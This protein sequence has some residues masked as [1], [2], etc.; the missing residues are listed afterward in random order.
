M[1]RYKFI[2]CLLFLTALLFSAE[3]DMIGKLYKLAQSLQVAEMA[4]R[5]AWATT[6]EPP[7]FRLAWISDAHVMNQASIANAQQVM[8]QLRDE[9][10]P[11]G[12]LVTGDNCGLPPKLLGK[13]PKDQVAFRRHAWFRDLLEKELGLPYIVLHGDNWASS[14]SKV[15]GP[16]HKSCDFGGFH[17]IQLAPDS[18]SP[19]DNGCAVYEQET[20]DW[21]EKDIEEHSTMPTL[22]LQHEPIY[23][24]CILDASKIE[25]II[26]KHNARQHSVIAVLSGHLHLDLQFQRKGWTQLV[27]PALGTGQCYAFK[28]LAFYADR[29]ILTTYE[30]NAEQ[31]KYLPV[32]K[33]QRIIIP[34]GARPT[35]ELSKP[36]AIEN[37]AD[38]PGKDCRVDESLG[39]REEELKRSMMNALMQ[40]V[41][42]VK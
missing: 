37:L 3:Q 2:L 17:F 31:G 12:I 42:F 33:W 19:K 13:C 11:D 24:P 14:Y 9:L 23:P 36:L 26:K 10:R 29:I 34:S 30:F 18:Q 21:L 20:L 1:S 16:H 38:G 4:E 40:A 7:L 6:D 39:Q 27:C 25:D 35:G 15:F 8:H 28:M 5:P 41:L 32:P 22:I